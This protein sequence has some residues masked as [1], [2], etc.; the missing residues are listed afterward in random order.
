MFAAFS[1]ADA[2]A[3]ETHAYASALGPYDI[4]SYF[5]TLHYAASSEDVLRRQFAFWEQQLT[6][7]GSVIVQTVD[8]DVLMHRL[9]EEWIRLHTTFSDEEQRTFCAPVPLR[10]TNRFYA[11]EWPARQSVQA[12]H[13][14]QP[15][16]F[17]F[18]A[19]MAPTTEYLMRAEDLLRL[20]GEHGLV[21]TRDTNTLQGIKSD[22][23]RNAL[24]EDERDVVQLYRTYVFERVCVRSSL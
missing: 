8:A 14:G 17:T 2:F 1:C 6:D 5:N 18:L 21:C 10:L 22:A 19:S 3:P 7:T 16:T 4:I 12:M 23:T 9:N 24:T 13:T 20:A 15:Y 11:I